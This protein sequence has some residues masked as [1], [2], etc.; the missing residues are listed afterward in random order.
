MLGK[1]TSKQANA[2]QEKAAA[3]DGEDE[4]I[5][6]KVEASE[7]L[8]FAE[9]DKKRKKAKHSQDPNALP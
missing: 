2:G 9:P 3:A 6:Q 4:S 7:I 5:V 8:T 1:R